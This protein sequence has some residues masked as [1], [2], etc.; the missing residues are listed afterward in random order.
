MKKILS[1]FLFIALLPGYT[2][3]GE[4]SSQMSGVEQEHRR[5]RGPVRV[6]VEEGGK[7]IKFSHDDSDKHTTDTDDDDTWKFLNLCAQILTP[8]AAVVVGGWV[9]RDQYK[10]RKNG[11]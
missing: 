7:I 6:E 11:Q 4:S 8:L 2:L 9:A 3:A 10:K 1:F 5:L